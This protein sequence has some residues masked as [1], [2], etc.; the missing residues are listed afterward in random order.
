MV[1]RDQDF[2]KMADN[3][4]PDAKN[5]VVLR[6]IHVREG[7]TYHIYEN[8]LGQI[9]LDPQVSIPVAEAW[10]YKNPEALASLR[11]GLD[12]ATRGKVSKINLDE[13]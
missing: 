2:E 11:R 1:I 6:S 13:L 10:L 8:S 4:K 9:V 3:V 5:R 12:D 7:V